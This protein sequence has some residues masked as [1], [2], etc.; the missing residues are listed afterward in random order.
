MRNLVLPAR[1]TLY[2]PLFIESLLHDV[3]HEPFSG[4]A[5]I[6]QDFDHLSRNPHKSATDIQFTHNG[7]Q[8]SGSI[9]RN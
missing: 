7:E 1:I 6:Q 8:R 3:G 4:R 2:P 9:D 5:R